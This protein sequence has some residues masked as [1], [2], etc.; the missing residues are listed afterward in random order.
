MCF[1]SM[2]KNVGKSVH[3]FGK[4]QIILLVPLAVVSGSLVAARD[5]YFRSVKWAEEKRKNAPFAG[6]ACG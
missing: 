1:L 6:S 2:A 3:T 5:S 4:S